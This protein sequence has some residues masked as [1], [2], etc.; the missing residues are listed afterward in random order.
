MEIIQQR[1]N[2]EIQR[3]P[4]RE[5]HKTPQFDNANHKNANWETVGVKKIK[6][7]NNNKKKWKK[8]KKLRQIKKEKRENLQE[9]Q[10]MGNNQTPRALHE[11]VS[12]QKSA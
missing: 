3:V 4:T 1:N 11:Y 8:Q 10:K 9:A 6:M 12:A 5:L 2:Q 7:G